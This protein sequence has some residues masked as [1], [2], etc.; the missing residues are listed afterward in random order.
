MENTGKF[1]RTEA[2][3]YPLTTLELLQKPVTSN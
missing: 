2:A 1:E 3:V